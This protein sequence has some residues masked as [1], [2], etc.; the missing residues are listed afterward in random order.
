MKRVINFSGGK[1]SALMTII[2]KPTEDDIVLFTDTGREHPLTYKFID[3]FAKYENINVIK[4]KH[5][6]GF[7]KFKTSLPNRVTRMCTT[8]LKIMTAKRYL[9][10]VNVRTFEN[11]IGFRADE[12]KRVNNRKQKFKKVFDRF[13]LVDLGITKHDVNTYWENKSYNLQIP[14]IL[15]NCDLCFLK[16]KNAIINILRQHPQ[17]ADKWIEDEKRTKKTYFKDITYQELLNISKNQK[18]IFDLNK[19]LPAYNCECNSI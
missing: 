16:G 14:S 11:Y 2:L 13:P 6:L 18:T 12:M 5:E 17:L 9:R 7:N 15:G 1:T 3:D 10:S 8:D 4:V 19:V